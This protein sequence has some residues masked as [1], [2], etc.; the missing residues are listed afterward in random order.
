MRRVLLHP[1][2]TTSLTR[3]K[4]RSRRNPLQFQRFHRPSHLTNSSPLTPE[5]LG[6]S[7]LLFVKPNSPLQFLI[8]ASSCVATFL[9]PPGTALSQSLLL[10]PLLFNLHSPKR[11]PPSSRNLTSSKLARFSRSFVIVFARRAGAELLLTEDA[12]AIDVL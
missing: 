5:L 3:T 4:C 2:I 10:R 7:K 8:T 1:L 12:T 6:N 9:L 11:S